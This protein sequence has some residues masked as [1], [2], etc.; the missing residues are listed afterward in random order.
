MYFNLI[1]QLL[2][3]QTSALSCTLVTMGMHG[4]VHQLFID[5]KKVHGYR[6]RS[7]LFDVLTQSTV[8]IKILSLIKI[9]VSETCKKSDRPGFILIY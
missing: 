1:V 5:C 9:C 3:R 4:A 2:T 8:P 6:W 7:G